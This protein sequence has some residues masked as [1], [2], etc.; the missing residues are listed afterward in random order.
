MYA[1]IVQNSFPILTRKASVVPFQASPFITVC[2]YTGSS[3]KDGLLISSSE[4]A[5]SSAQCEPSIA[6]ADS[7]VALSLLDHM[8]GWVSILG[9][10]ATVQLP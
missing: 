6:G 5:G 8:V 1:I 10:T 3:C 9:C 2:N 4:D 7:S